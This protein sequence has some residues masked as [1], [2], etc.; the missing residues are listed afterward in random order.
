MPTGIG[1][2]LSNFDKGI[3]CKVESLEE[4]AGNYSLEIRELPKPQRATAELEP[5]SRHEDRVPRA[6]KNGEKLKR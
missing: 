1:K 6:S 4:A 2:G 3:C 5:K